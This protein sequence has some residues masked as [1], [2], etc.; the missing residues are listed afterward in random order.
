MKY[1]DLKKYMFLIYVW[2]LATV[3]GSHFPKPLDFPQGYPKEASFVT[4]L[5]LLSSV[6]KNTS[7]PKGEK[8]F[9]FYNKPLFA[10]TGYIH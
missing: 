5:G 7:E 1:Y 10:T 8:G 4:I 9:L 6:S 3:P 2:F